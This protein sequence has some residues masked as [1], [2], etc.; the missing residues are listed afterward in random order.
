MTNTKLEQLT[1]A[2]QLAVPSIM[3]LELGCKV[4]I[5]DKGIYKFVAYK[6]S[7]IH[8]LFQGKSEQFVITEE[9]LKYDKTIKIIGRD[10]T[11]IDILKTLGDNFVI[12]SNGIL[13]KIKNFEGGDNWLY[14][15]LEC[16]I[17]L[18][19]PFQDQS[20]ETKDFLWDLICK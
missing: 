7:G 19:V 13:L 6:S 11:P 5:L 10:I 8:L 12:D 2:I 14:K 15:C 3:R 18:N 20:D 17:D 1:K 4:E 16:K 9:M